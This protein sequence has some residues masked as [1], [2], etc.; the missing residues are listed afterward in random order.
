MT[1]NEIRAFAPARA[2]TIMMLLMA[3]AVVPT[4]WVA[5]LPSICLAR[6]LFGVECPGCGMTRAISCVLHGD[7]PTALRYNKL[8][9][10]LFPL[11]CAVLALDLW[12]WVRRRSGRTTSS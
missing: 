8:V 10:L 11:L 5:A 2:A 1:A 4:R 7:F 12:T 9:A 3:L 6:N